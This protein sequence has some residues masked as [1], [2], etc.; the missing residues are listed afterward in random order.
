MQRMKTLL[1]A[2]KNFKSEKKRVVPRRGEGRPNIDRLNTLRQA[3]DPAEQPS[4]TTEIAGMTGKVHTVDTS[5]ASDQ[6]ADQQAVNSAETVVPLG[7]KSSRR[8]P[9]QDDVDL[10]PRSHAPLSLTPVLQRHDPIVCERI[11]RHHRHVR[12]TVIRQDRHENV[13]QHVLQPIYDT[14]SI[15]EPPTEILLPDESE[16]VRAEMNQDDSAKY[17]AIYAKLAEKARTT[18]PVITHEYVD[19]EPIIEDKVVRH[20]V[21][22]VHPVIERDIYITHVIREVKHVNRKFVDSNRVTGLHVADAISLDE[23][24]R[25]LSSDT[26]MEVPTRTESLQI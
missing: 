22:E 1:K 24:Q 21:Q 14:Q 3:K 4:S 15:E 13:H 11:N 18:V 6:I 7:Q 19:E 10:V 8:R 5:L 9:I 2:E 20:I 25:R 17:R 16:T 26:P 12:Q 23:W